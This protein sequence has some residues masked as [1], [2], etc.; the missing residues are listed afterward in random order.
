MF[1][2]F[3]FSLESTGQLVKTD[4]PG[5]Y[6]WR[7]WFSRLGNYNFSNLSRWFWCTKKENDLFPG[8]V[9]A[10]QDNV[11]IMKGAT[12][13]LS[14][15]TEQRTFIKTGSKNWDFLFHSSSICNVWKCIWSHGKCPWAERRG[16]TQEE[17][18]LKRSNEEWPGKPIRKFS[19]DKHST[20]LSLWSSS[21]VL[22]MTIAP[23]THH[24][25]S[26]YHC[27]LLLWLTSG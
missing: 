8:M 24:W 5:F 1:V 25:W 14:L 7:F 12:G 20:E 2:K 4:I 6:P 17:V 11:I 13:F 23:L 22:C 3:A 18:R 9:G 19:W 10:E 15:L 27:T 21:A 26:L 16:G